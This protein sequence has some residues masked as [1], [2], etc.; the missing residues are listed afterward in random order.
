MAIIV[1]LA[2]GFALAAGITGSADATGTALKDVAGRE[3]GQGNTRLTIDNL[4]GS[5][6][7]GYFTFSLNN[8]G[9]AKIENV[10]RIDVIAKVVD[11]DVAWWFPYKFPGTTPGQYWE[12]A[13]ITSLAPGIGDAINPGMLDPGETLLV[14]V[15]GPAPLA[16]HDLWVQ[17][18]APN[19]VSASYEWVI[20]N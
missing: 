14:S 20:G 16:G 18:T 6:A 13:G 19:G 12:C 10:S 11:G 5:V 4:T 7:G 3:L 15:R 8:V 2:A 17:A 1:L 9:N